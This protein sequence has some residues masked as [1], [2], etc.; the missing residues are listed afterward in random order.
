MAEKSETRS[1]PVTVILSSSSPTAV[2]V[3]WTWVS[4]FLLVFHSSTH[5]NAFMPHVSTSVSS[6]SNKVFNLR[7]QQSYTISLPGNAHSQS[8]VSVSSVRV[9]S[10]LCMAKQNQTKRGPPGAG[11]GKAKA[12][13]TSKKNNK[14]VQTNGNYNGNSNVQSKKK[15]GKD[16]KQNTSPNVSASSS[17]SSNMNNTPKK[18]AHLPPWQVMSAKDIKKNIESEIQ[19]RNAVRDGTLP[20]SVV[21]SSTADTQAD[22]TASSSL[23]TNT[24]RQLFNF[25]RFDPKRDIDSMTFKGAFLGNR[26]PPRLGVPEVAFLGRSNVGKSSLLNTLSKKASNTSQMDTAV[27]GKTPGATASVN[28]YSLN[29]SAAKKNRPLLA[30]ADLPGFGYAKLSKEVKESVEMAAERYLGKRKELALGI[31]LVDVRRVP[32]DDDR[33]VLAA[34]YDMGVPILVVAT[35]IDK[36]GSKNMLEKQLEEVRVGLGLPLGQPF[37]V[38]SVTGLGIKQ[39]WGIIMDACED[40]ID[41][42]REA[43]ETGGESKVSEDDAEAFGN[44]QLDEDG[45]YLD[46]EAVAEGY[47]WIQS[48]AYHDDSNDDS[49]DGAG[50]VFGSGNGNANGNGKRKELSEEARMKM[51]E[52]EDMQAAENEA[53]KVKNLRK[54]VK[55]MQREGKV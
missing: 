18:S 1:R 19:R 33:A 3:S 38:S 10:P 41:E 36:I 7:G 28:L 12:K 29:A 55:K 23:L 6:N 52:N 9:P 27:V 40:K 46:D 51:K 37:S 20:S 49:K 35:K 44:V 13:A 5:V 53:G 48:F 4:F 47:E 39:L 42:L 22:I 34:L 45:N 8:Q 43:V 11:G 14:G 17:S 54:V 25:K 15:K 16:T 2:W 32:S 31:L 26:T 24:D 30:F 50:A 21:T